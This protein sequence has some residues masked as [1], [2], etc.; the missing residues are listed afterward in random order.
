MRGKV[1]QSEALN[2]CL[3]VPALHSQASH[4]PV[5]YLTSCFQGKVRRSPSL[6]RTR[7]CPGCPAAEHRNGKWPQNFQCI[8]SNES[9][10]LAYQCNKCAVRL[11]KNQ[12]FNMT[13]D[14]SQSPPTCISYLSYIP[15]TLN[16]G[17]GEL[18]KVWG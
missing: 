16:P 1:L 2:I 8:T 4:H 18:W 11:E 5:F 3:G 15:H 6:Q 13:D 17:S 7:W 10:L 14:N 12:V 9:I